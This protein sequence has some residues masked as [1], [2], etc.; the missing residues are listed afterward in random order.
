MSDLILIPT[1]NEAGNIVPLL[2]ELRRYCPEAQLWVLDD[3]SEDGTAERARQAFA[4]DPQV[5]VR[6]RGG[7]RGLGRTYREGYAW[8]LSRGFDRLCQMDADFSHDPADVPRLLAALEGADLAIGSR[9]VPGGGSA[10]WPWYRRAL[11]RGGGWLG[12]KL[13]GLPVRDVSG[14]FYAMTAKALKAIDPA[15]LTA[16][17]FSIQFENRCRAQRAGLRMVEVPILFRDRTAGR[18]K[19]RVLRE[20]VAHLRLALRQRLGL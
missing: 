7:A 8:A 12:M 10:H 18:S 11:S 2:R 20:I 15:S 16:D 14:G 9:Y 17:D 6:V 13:S 1:W 19:M 4:G 5:E 3:R